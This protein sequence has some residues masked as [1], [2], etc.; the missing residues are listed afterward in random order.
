MSV[1]HLVVPI[2]HPAT[3]PLGLQERRQEG[4][5]AL[6]LVLSTHLEG[7]G[8][9]PEEVVAVAAGG[10]LGAVRI[11]IQARATITLLLAPQARRT[12]HRSA[13]R[14]AVVAMVV[15]MDSLL[16]AVARTVAAATVAQG[17]SAGVEHAHR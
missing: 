15:T 7:L 1:G 10:S 14:L 9:Q 5:L 6:A 12:P 16:I 2:R 8:T 4:V 3:L 17:Y 11:R 13:R